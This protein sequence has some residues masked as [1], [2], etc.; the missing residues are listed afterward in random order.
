MRPCKCRLKGFRAIQVCLDD[1]AG[2]FAMLGRIAS[3]GAYLELMA[4]LK[5]AYYGAS[6]L[7]RCA[8]YRDKLLICGFHV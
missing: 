7:P 3:Q 5:G 1:F 6:L 4:S 8:D 2:E